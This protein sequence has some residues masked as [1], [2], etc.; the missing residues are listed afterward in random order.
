MTKVKE[1]QQELCNDQNQVVLM[2]LKLICLEID[3]IMNNTGIFLQA[4][5][6]TVVEA[7][8]DN[9]LGNVCLVQPFLLI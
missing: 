4:N 9:K 8:V 2:L 1:K 5:K 7:N 3:T 6:Q